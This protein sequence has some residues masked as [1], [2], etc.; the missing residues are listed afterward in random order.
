MVTTS[1]AGLA[2]MTAIRPKTGSL[3]VCQTNEGGAGLSGLPRRFLAV[4][5]AH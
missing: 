1:A 3:S 2:S 5:R 4:Q